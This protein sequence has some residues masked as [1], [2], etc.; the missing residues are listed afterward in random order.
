LL[1]HRPSM[2]DWTSSPSWTRLQIW[3]SDQQKRTGWPRITSK[4]PVAS[5]M[6]SR[7]TPL[8]SS[9]IQPLLH[10]GGWGDLRAELPGPESCLSPSEVR[11][12]KKRLGRDGKRLRLSVVLNE[13]PKINVD[14]LSI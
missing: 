6:L 10:W 9:R 11:S 3:Q 2:L 7:Q 8:R 1:S 5:W 14:F 13:W 4:L 12:L